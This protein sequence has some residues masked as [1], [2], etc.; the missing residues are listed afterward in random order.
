MKKLYWNYATGGVELEKS[1][2]NCPIIKGS[3]NSIVTESWCTDS[4]HK[5][6]INFSH[7]RGN[8]YDRDK[9][10]K[11]YN[12]NPQDLRWLMIPKFEYEELE[13]HYLA[14]SER[15]EIIK[16]ILKEQE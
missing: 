7:V 10:F 8:A 15:L 2:C 6:A 1:E 11:E 3:D 9:F 12:V 4:L 5:Y 13:T 16:Q 14:R